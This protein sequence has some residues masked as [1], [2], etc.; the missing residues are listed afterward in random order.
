MGRPFPVHQPG[1]GIRI[2]GLAVFS[3][4]PFLYVTQGVRIGADG[5]IVFTLIVCTLCHGSRIAN[6]Q[7]ALIVIGS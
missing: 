4:I 1:I 3:G 2:H 6:S 5:G 7:V